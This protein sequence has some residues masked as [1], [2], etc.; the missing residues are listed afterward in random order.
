MGLLLANKSYLLV[1]L[2]YSHFVNIFWAYFSI[3]ILSFFYSTFCEYYITHR[4]LIISK[5]WSNWKYV[6]WCSLGETRKKHICWVE[7]ITY[8][9][10]NGVI[11]YFSRFYNVQKTS[12]KN[13]TKTSTFIA[14]KKNNIFLRM[15]LSY[16][17][18]FFSTQKLKQKLARFL[19][20]KN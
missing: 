13:S 6:L 7:K 16:I 18:Q 3:K 15:E 5:K 2:L 17:S 1:V 14:L 4:W 12:T 10:E 20:E 8:S 19:C 11:I 9:T